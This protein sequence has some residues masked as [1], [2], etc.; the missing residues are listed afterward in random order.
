MLDYLRDSRPGWISK[1]YIDNA[2]AGAGSLPGVLDPT[3]ARIEPG[4]T[5]APRS[6]RNAAHASSTCSRPPRS[7]WPRRRRPRTSSATPTS[8]RCSSRRRRARPHRARHHDREGRRQPAQPVRRRSA[9]SPTAPT[10]RP[11]AGASS[12][13]TSTCKANAGVPA[14]PIRLRSSKRVIS[15][16]GPNGEHEDVPRA[17]DGPEHRHLHDPR[18]AGARAARHRGQR[19]PRRPPERRVR[20]GDPR[21]RPAHLDAGHADGALE[22]GVRQP[23]QRSRS[24]MRR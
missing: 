17:G 11:R 22:R 8:P 7:S 21:L 5:H 12:A 16:T 14:T 1:V 24:P 13:A 15:I 4:W 23:H 2:S 20:R 3:D 18:D 10:P 9:T 6:G 19:H